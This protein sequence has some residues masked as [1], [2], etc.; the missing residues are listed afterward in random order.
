MT[1]EEESN[2]VKEIKT[3]LEKT[4]GVQLVERDITVYKKALTKIPTGPLPP[5]DKTLE[6][7][8]TEYEKKLEKLN[9]KINEHGIVKDIEESD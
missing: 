5:I 1:P 2:L 9:K 4:N 3:D 7:Q 6:N 8:K